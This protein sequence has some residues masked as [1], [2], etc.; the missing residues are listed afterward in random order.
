MKSKELIEENKIGYIFIKMSDKEID[1]LN[2][3]GR[4]Y[5]DENYAKT[6]PSYQEFFKSYEKTMHLI[7]LKIFD[8]E[9][10]IR[11]QECLKAEDEVNITFKNF[12][13]LFG[14][15]DGK[16]LVP[17]LKNFYDKYGLEILDSLMKS[18]IAQKTNSTLNENNL[19]EHLIFKFN[20]EE[21][22]MKKVASVI[23]EI[24]QQ[25]LP[26][27]EVAIIL[28]KNYHSYGVDGNLLN[29]KKE[30]EYFCDYFNKNDNYYL[31][32]LIQKELEKD[33]V[34]NKKQIQKLLFY[35]NQNIINKNGKIEISIFIFS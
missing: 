9:E 10:K 4:Y 21:Q 24:I 8:I 17:R 15:S 34:E 12:N 29:M 6:I 23:K 1:K 28:S 27:A 32:N 3:M 14:Y 19:L 2:K 26:Y 30:S 35:K 31:K 5:L 20:F 22:D 7:A 33:F 18:E 11:K 25:E 16:D 13:P